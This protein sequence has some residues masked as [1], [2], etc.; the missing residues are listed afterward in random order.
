[1][2]HRGLIGAVLYAKDL[3]RLVPFYASVAG[4]E[5]QT[6]EKAFAI[7]GFGPSRLVVVRIPGEIA[8]RIDIARPPKPREET[9]LKLVFAVDDIARARD[10]AAE[11]GGAVNAVESEWEFEGARVCDGHDPEGNI[12]QLRQMS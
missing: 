5:V 11:L 10:R 1:M 7:L 12:F 9:P 8:A 2:T 4:I 3:G 6:I